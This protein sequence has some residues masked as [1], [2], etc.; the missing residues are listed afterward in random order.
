MKNKKVKKISNDK[1]LNSQTFGDLD[2]IYFYSFENFCNVL[3]Q[4]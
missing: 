4:S 2:F 3:F 1:I